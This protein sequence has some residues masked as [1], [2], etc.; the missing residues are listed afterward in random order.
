MVWSGGTSATSDEAQ[1]L[2]GSYGRTLELTLITLVREE[3]SWVAE[4]ETVPEPVFI[5]PTPTPGG[6]AE[7][8]AE[9]EEVKAIG[10]VILTEPSLDSP[11]EPGEFL[12]AR[13]EIIGADGAYLAGQPYD[14][15]R[16]RVSVRSAADDS[17]LTFNQTGSG[18]NNS[19]YSTWITIPEDAEE[20]EYYLEITAISTAY[21]GNDLEL[22]GDLKIPL[23]VETNE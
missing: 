7:N 16:I 4:P 11:F 14:N 2:L 21:H 10:V 17:M 1:D 22:V 23:I 15:L 12:V 6:E 20:G 3:Q 19:G 9:P 8:G 18:F 5:P 13:F